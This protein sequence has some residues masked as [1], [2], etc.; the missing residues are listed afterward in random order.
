MMAA[1]SRGKVKINIEECKGCGLCVDSCPPKCLS[2]AAELNA[3]GAHPA[4]YAGEGCT[5]CGI[6]F[7]CCPEPGAITVYRMPAPAR[8]VEATHAASV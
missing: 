4:A 1:V 3:Y 2:L 7:Y 8:A 6:C 5:G